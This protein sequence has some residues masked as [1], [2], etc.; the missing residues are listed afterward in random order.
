VLKREITFSGDVLNTTSRIQELCNKYNEK[1]IV[2]KDFLDLMNLKNKFLLKEIGQM[3]LRGRSAPII[4]YTVK[5][6]KCAIK[7][8]RNF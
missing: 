2:S 8:V 7:V 6:E 1:L 4:L 5:K 3:N